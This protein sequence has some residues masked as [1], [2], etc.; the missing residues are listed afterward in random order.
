MSAIEPSPSPPPPEPPPSP[1][2]RA[3]SSGAVSVAAGILSSRILAV[4]REAAFAHYFG[5]G[6]HAD[7]WTAALRVPNMLQNLL[8][9]GALS[10]AFIP[11]YS[12]LLASG[13]EKE[14]GRF[15]GAIFGLLLVAASSLALLGILLSKPL[16]VL[17]APGFLGDAA[18]V[19]AGQLQVNRFDLCVHAVRILF[20]MAG[21]MVLSVWALGILNSHRRFFLPYFAPVLWNVALITSLILTG[22]WLLHGG[23]VRSLGPDALTT[24]L[25][26]ACWG[27][28]AGG[29]LQ[30]AVQLPVVARV[31]RGFRF[32]FSPAVP[33]VKEA[34]KAWGP[35]V[36]G[37]GVVQLAGYMDLFLASLL[38]VGASSADRNAQLL[39]ILPISLFGMSMAASE[40]PELSRLHGQGDEPELLRRVLGVL[41]SMAFLN[42]PTVVGY[43]CFGW[44]FVGAIYR[45]GAFTIGDNWL[46]WL[47]L[48]GYSLGILATTSS[49]L[50][51][52]TFYAL[53]ESKVPARIAMQRVLTSVLVALPLM[54]VLDH[55]PLSVLIGAKAGVL[56]LGSV[57]LSAAS[58]AGAW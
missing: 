28:L 41:R 26:A 43:L 33:G 8:G 13:R 23:S 45:T 51:Q 35:V 54:F 58:A 15:A 57:G 12:R 38:F 47:V 19:A 46:V 24:L 50:L 6:A 34:L 29:V 20:P 11:I 56:R 1:Q 14:A 55:Y 17:L 10:A 48:C 3:R 4:V 37:R 2:A 27:G 31:L 39:Y 40:L 53:G 52:N 42:V 36:A 7:A 49:R 21:V 30:F 44:L 9:E 18:K 25:Y 16:I 5:V 22:R 32:S